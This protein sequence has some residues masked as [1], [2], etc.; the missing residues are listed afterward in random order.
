MSLHFL[1]RSIPNYIMPFCYVLILT[2]FIRLKFGVLRATE[3]YISPFLNLR[4]HFSLIGAFV[5]PQRRNL[6]LYHIT[7]SLLVH[8]LRI[9]HFRITKY[10][11][12]ER[13]AIKHEYRV[14]H[15]Y[16]SNLQ[17][18]LMDKQL[19]KKHNLIDTK[20]LK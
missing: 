6:E 14:S 5:W 7:I 15:Q 13:R 19:L 3:K 4:S 11:K 8:Y 10:I 18:W 9:K 1:Y 16:Y 20:L 2:S 17:C 12:D